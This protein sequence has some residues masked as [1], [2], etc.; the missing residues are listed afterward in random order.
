LASELAAESDATAVHARL[1][2][3]LRECLESVAELLGADE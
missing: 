1:D 2:A 3:E